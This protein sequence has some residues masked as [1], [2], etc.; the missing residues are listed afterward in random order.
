MYRIPLLSIEFHQKGPRIAADEDWGE[1]W[2]DRWFLERDHGQ[3]FYR[4]GEG[5]AKGIGVENESGLR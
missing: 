3:F 2:S 5:F 4:P 1:L